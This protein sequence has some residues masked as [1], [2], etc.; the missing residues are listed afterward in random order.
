VKLGK[1]IATIA[2]ACTPVN[3]ARHLLA[4]LQT[5]SEVLFEITEDFVKRC[6]SLKIVSFF[7]TELTHIHPFWKTFVCFE[8]PDR[9]SP[10]MAA[11]DRSEGLGYLGCFTRINRPPEC[12]PSPDCSFQVGT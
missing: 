2:A 12:R 4:S 9:Q 8:I 1:V 10:L 5:D 7:E 6:S 3:P 11:P